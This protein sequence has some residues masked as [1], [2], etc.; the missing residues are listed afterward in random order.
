M[1]NKPIRL[2]LLLI[3]LACLTI[4][5]SLAIGATSI[6][7]AVLFYSPTCAHCQQVIN[8]D[9]PPIGKQYGD[10]LLIIGIDTSVPEGAQMYQAAI[11]RFLIPENRRGVPAIIVGD[12]VLVGINEKKVGNKGGKK[13]CSLHSLSRKG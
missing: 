7:R 8:E 11:A 13:H 12:T 9:L 6:V 2:V 4:P 10:Q 1:M 5:Q 3:I